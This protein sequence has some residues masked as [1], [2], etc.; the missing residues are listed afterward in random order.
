[1]FIYTG[2]YKI[3]YPSIL[4]ES[5]R[6]QSGSNYGDSFEFEQNLVVLLSALPT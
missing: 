2:F 5:I 1:M 4:A 3:Y 6:E